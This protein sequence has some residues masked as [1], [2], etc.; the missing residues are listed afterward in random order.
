MDIIAKTCHDPLIE[1]MAERSNQAFAG[2][3]RHLATDFLHLQG[4]FPYMPA[5]ILCTD[6]N[7]YQSFKAGIAEY[8]AQ[9]HGSCFLELSAGMVNSQNPLAYNEKSAKH[10][11]SAHIHVFRR[12]QTSV[13]IELYNQLLCQG[14]L[15]QEHVIGMLIVLYKMLLIWLALCRSTLSRVKVYQPACS[16]WPFTLAACF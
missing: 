6:F 9:F 13:S 12:S 2:F 7:R 14:L 15:D 5:Y 3:G 11:Y 16:D 8:I 10:Y 1:V 4:I